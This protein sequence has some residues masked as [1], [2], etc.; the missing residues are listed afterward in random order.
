[1]IWE[2][3]KLSTTQMCPGRIFHMAT[4]AMDSRLGANVSEIIPICI[5]FQSPCP[6]MIEPCRSTGSIWPFIH[7]EY[8]LILNRTWL[9]FV[10]IIFAHPSQD[11]IPS[12]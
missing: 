3:E 9:P 12:Y 8:L 10:H 7:V 6:T 4:I 11:P 5:N 2:R 1:M